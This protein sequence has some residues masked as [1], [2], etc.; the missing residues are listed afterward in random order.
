MARH[1]EGRGC[2]SEIL[3]KVMARHD[4]RLSG[5]HCT[6]REQRRCHHCDLNAFECTVRPTINSTVF[7]SFLENELD[8]DLAKS[9]RENKLGL[10]VPVN[11]C[12]PTG[13]TGG[14]AVGLQG[15]FP[16]G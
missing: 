4:M 11:T 9:H 3:K 14:N 2:R 7:N 15:L 12:A 8:S 10:L 16:M 1:G 5:L 13:H 6:V